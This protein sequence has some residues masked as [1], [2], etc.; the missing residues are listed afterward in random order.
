MKT[1]ILIS[2]QMRS[3][4][5]CI[6]NLNW[7]VFRR[8]ENPTFFVSCADDEQAKDAFLLE[9]YSERVFIERVKQPELK[10][11]AFSL[12]RHS[13]YAPT[14]NNPSVIQPILK[15][16]WHYKRVWDFMREV[17]TGK[18]GEEAI[19]PER[20]LDFDIFVRCRP[21]LF[22]HRFDVRFPAPDWFIGPWKATC[23]GVNDRFSIM[24]AVAAKAYFNAGDKLDDLL[25]A[26]CPFHPES[27]QQAALEAAGC[28]ISNTLQ[29]EFTAMRLPGAGPHVPLVEYPG[30]LARFI[31]ETGQLTYTDKIETFR[32][33][34]GGGY[35]VHPLGMD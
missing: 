7:T 34:G 12:C 10:E 33:G 2:G 24:G 14:P 4:A 25:E 1:A 21:D 32:G 17:I 19:E 11:P 15:Q 27:I 20:Q 3:F 5:S 8:F 6:A 9:A 18:E 16:L 31:D 29:A 13:P 23:G 30:E 26:G 22:F 28:H 35:G